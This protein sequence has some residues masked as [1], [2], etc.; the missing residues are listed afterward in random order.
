M[1]V[2]LRLLG[3]IWICALLIIAAFAFLEVR[4]ERQRLVDNLERRATLLGEALRESVQPAMRQGSTP[5]IAR[6]F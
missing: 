3:A 4:Q 6:A 5:R 2:T 1:R